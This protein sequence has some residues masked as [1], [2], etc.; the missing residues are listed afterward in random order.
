MGILHQGIIYKAISKTVFPRHTPPSP[1]PRPAPFVIPPPF[2]IPAQAGIQRTPF[3]EAPAFA[4]ATRGDAPAEAGI[5]P[6]DSRFHG[7]DDRLG[8]SSM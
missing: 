6:L 4:G 8:C 2:V 1:R 7:N 5:H 3:P